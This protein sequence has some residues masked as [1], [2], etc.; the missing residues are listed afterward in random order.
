MMD[1][2]YNVQAEMQELIYHCKLDIP[3][4]LLKGVIDTCQESVN[5]TL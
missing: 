1:G 5:W 2:E 3:N 4:D